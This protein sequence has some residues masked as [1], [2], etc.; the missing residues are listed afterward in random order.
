[1]EMK[2][3]KEVANKLLNRKEMLL[4]VTYKGSTPSREEIK[5]AAARKFN[6]KH[7]NVVIVSIDQIYGTGES[8]VLI[9]EY[10]SEEAKANAQK[11]VLARPNKKGKGEAA[12]AKPEAKAAGGA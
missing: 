11:H 7:E 12:E 8:R 5:D 4:D 3:E 2:L 10:A 9:H 1:M 6:L